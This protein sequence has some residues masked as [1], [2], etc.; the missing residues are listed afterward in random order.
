[1]IVWSL[2]PAGNDL[3]ARHSALSEHAVSLFID[4]VWICRE[5]LIM[6]LRLPSP[7][8]PGKSR[9]GAAVEEAQ[10]FMIEGLRY[11]SVTYSST[12]RGSRLGQDRKDFCT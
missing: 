4:P 12:D 9:R 5:A 7:P 11:G 8:L 1:M 6:G 2:R 10:E 3:S